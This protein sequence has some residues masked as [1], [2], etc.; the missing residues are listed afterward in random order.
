MPNYTL[1]VVKIECEGSIGRQLKATVTAGSE[2]K[3]FGFKG[4]SSRHHIIAK[5][6]TFPGESVVVPVKIEVTEEDPIASDKPFSANGTLVISAAGMRPTSLPIRVAEV[7]GKGTSKGNKATIRFHFEA[8]VPFSIRSIPGIMTVNE[9]PVGSK[10]MNRWFDSS[11]KIRPAESQTPDTDSITMAW[12]FGFGRVRDARDEI[13]KLK[14][15]Q[16]KNCVALIKKKYGSTI[17]AFGDFTLPVSELHQHQMQYRL[18][19]SGWSFSGIDDLFCALG[20]FH[21]YVTVKGIADAKEIKITH[22]GIHMRDEYEFNGDQKL[23][24]WNKDTNY[25]GFIRPRGT[26]VSNESFNK[27][28]T[29]TGRGGDFEVFSKDVTVIELPKPL[30][31]KK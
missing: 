4:T 9:W 30:I 14:L 16:T 29:E 15:L 26:G 21:L 7:G 8:E 6:V 23:G 19:K 27:H 3:T 24:Y 2:T 28:R 20:D 12:L 11:A 17:G 10:F 31:I 5:A 25:G 1:K 22:I 13:Q 18:V